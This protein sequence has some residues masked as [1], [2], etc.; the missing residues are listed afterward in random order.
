M[1][2]YVP[3]YLMTGNPRPVITNAPT[4]L[5]Y[6]APFSLTYTLTSPATIARQGGFIRHPLFS[7]AACTPVGCRA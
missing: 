1:Q 4:S 7:H 5:G 2:Y 3:G 6:N